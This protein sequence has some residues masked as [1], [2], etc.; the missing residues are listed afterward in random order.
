MPD[1]QARDIV[2]RLRKAPIA[3][4]QAMFGAHTLLADAADEICTLRSA[5][6]DAVRREG[7]ANAAKMRASHEIDRLTKEFDEAHQF[8]ALVRDYLSERDS[9]V[10]D[11]AMRRSLLNRIRAALSKKDEVE[12]SA[13]CFDCGLAYDDP[14]FQDLVL[15]DDVWARISPTGDE[16]G[17]LC[18][19][20]I[21]RRLH[22]AGINTRGTFGSGPLAALSK[23]T[24]AQ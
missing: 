5:L 16:G 4:G 13:A 18:P 10:P 24:G 3:V 14:G 7:A 9:P 8:K 22:V 20:C 19:S 2:E 12:S 15:D 11:H 17:L 23:A 21:C 1:A 6:G